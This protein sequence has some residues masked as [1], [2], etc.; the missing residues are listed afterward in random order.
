LVPFFEFEGHPPIDIQAA[1][2]ALQRAND[3][4]DPVT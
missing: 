2:P 4:R 3:W 1:L